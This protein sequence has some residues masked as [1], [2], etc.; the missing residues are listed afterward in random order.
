MDLRNI[1][2]KEKKVE[3]R[4]RKQEETEHRLQAQ[5]KTLGKAIAQAM[6]TEEKSSNKAPPPPAP[7]KT[8][9]P[10]ENITHRKLLGAP[11][12]SPK[13]RSAQLEE[14][15]S[16]RSREAEHGNIVAW[17]IDLAKPEQVKGPHNRMKLA[18][19]EEKDVIG[20]N[21]YIEKQR[22]SQTFKIICGPAK[23][24]RIL[25]GMTNW[26]TQETLFDLQ[27][28]TESYYESGIAYVNNYI[29]QI[30]DFPQKAP[31]NTGK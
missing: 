15:R 28:P 4:E 5:R 3:E 26:A 22:F 21:R 12:N 2:E 19:S 10:P 31:T 29:W 25:T 11:P 6:K 23:L 24:G 16:F 18:I 7:T 13:T 17:P 8:K 30:E 27:M 1:R 9:A 20:R 14:D